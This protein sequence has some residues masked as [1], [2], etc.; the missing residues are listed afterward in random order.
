MSGAA[1]VALRSGAFG[2]SRTGSG[3]V[4][5]PAANAA[6]A[7]VTSVDPGFYLVEVWAGLYTGAPVVATETR[8]MFISAGPTVVWILPIQPVVG[9]L[10]YF[11]A[12]VLVAAPAQ[13]AIQL[14]VVAN[15]T[16]GVGYF[17]NINVTRIGP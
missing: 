17:G 12:L 10:D 15:A 11:A 13:V 9:R 7:N 8:N 2:P 1:P 4:V 14:Q 6:I 3:Q 16:A 5:G